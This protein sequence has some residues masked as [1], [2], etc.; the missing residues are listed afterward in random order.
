MALGPLW[1]GDQM[2]RLGTLGRQHSEVAS[3]PQA[4]NDAGDVVGTSSTAAGAPRAF[5]WRH[6]TMIDLGT[7]GG[8]YSSAKAV[9]DRG[10]VVGISSDTS[11]DYRRTFLWRDGT[12]T[13]LGT[14]GGKDARPFALNNRGQVVGS[15]EDKTHGIRPTLWTT[16]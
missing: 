9:N 1:S 3:G 13:D 4:I 2:I 8:T 12:M 10:D 15:S 14:V 6:G 7:A 11:D 16:R 5:L